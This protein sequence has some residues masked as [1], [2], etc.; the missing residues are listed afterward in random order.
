MRESGESFGV[1]CRRHGFSF[2]RLAYWRT[3]LQDS[4]AVRS[5][6]AFIEIMPRAPAPVSTAHGIASSGVTVRCVGGAQVVVAA[7]FDPAVLRA[8][9]AVL[10][11]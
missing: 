3:R 4:E 1:Y 5:Q 10:S 11:P 6:S 2:A 8:V 7:G 9:V